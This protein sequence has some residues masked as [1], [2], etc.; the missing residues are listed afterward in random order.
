M[1]T[2]SNTFYTDE[3][4]RQI[5]DYYANLASGY[6]NV[7]FSW[8][9]QLYD[10]DQFKDSNHMNNHGALLFTRK[11]KEMYPDVFSDNTLSLARYLA[12]D[13]DIKTEYDLDYINEWIEGFD[14]T[15]ETTDNYYVVTN[16]YTEQI[17]EEGYFENQGEEQKIITGKD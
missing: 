5:N 14:Y 7:D 2:P 1:P 11:I 12:V 3:Y 17:V 8:P 10:I 4:V 9:V 13:Q 6:S 15:L 16:N